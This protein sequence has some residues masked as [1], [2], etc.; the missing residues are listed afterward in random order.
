MLR[1]ILLISIIIL[2]L[3]GL[4]LWTRPKDP[5]G[6]TTG[7]YQNCSYIPVEGDQSASYAICSLKYTVDNRI[8]DTN[9]VSN[10]NTKNG[11]TV[12]ID[13]DPNNPS[14]FPY[15]PFNYKTAS[16]VCFGLMFILIAILFFK[17]R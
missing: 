12:Q 1:I 9:Y 16:Y 14:I 7:V 10:F 2:L 5:V 13:Y 3:M 6:H 11:Q 4:Y 15:E 17:Y 8:Y